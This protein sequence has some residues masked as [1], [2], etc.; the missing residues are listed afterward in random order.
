L[1]VNRIN[2]DHR[3]GVPARVV[4]TDGGMGTWEISKYTT[5]APEAL[6]LLLA[7]S[8]AGRAHATI[9]RRYHRFDTA[10]LDVTCPHGTAVSINPTP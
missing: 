2:P 3:H 6:G 1:I 8:R 5:G 7:S 10:S 4:N 9:I